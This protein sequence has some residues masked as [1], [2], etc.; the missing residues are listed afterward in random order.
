MKKLNSELVEGVKFWSYHKDISDVL[1]LSKGIATTREKR[2]CYNDSIFIPQKPWRK[3]YNKEIAVLTSNY[4]FD[5]ISKMVGVISFKNEALAIKL[6]KLKYEAVANRTKSE[7][8]RELAKQLLFTKAFTEKCESMNNIIVAGLAFHR[9]G[10]NTV[11]KNKRTNKY[12]GLHLDSWDNLPLFRRKESPNRICINLSDESRYFLFL[13][14]PVENMLKYFNKKL[15]KQTVPD[16]ICNEFMSVWPDYPI[17]KVEIKPFEAYIAPTECVVHD[18][19]TETMNT[20]SF[21][22]TFRGFFKLKKTN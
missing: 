5:D 19:T 7:E 6:G 2:A 15:V 9:K 1:E 16:F 21:S 20:D 12:V 11:T 3:P 14:I 8:F 17:I 4:D 10:L 22:F 13:N 18:A